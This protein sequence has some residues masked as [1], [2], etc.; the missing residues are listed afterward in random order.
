MAKYAVIDIG[1]NS[2]KLSIFKVSGNNLL[3]GCDKI[4][5]SRI[6]ENVSKTNLISQ[7]GMDRTIQVFEEWK[8]LFQAVNEVKIVGTM[9]FRL[10]KNSNI[11]TKHLKQKYG[12][13]L[14]IISGDK[15]AELSFKA[16]SY[17]YLNSNLP[18]LLIDSG[19]ASTELILF[20]NKKILQ[21]YSFKI[22]AALLTEAA[23]SKN[24]ITKNEIIATKKIIKK[25][26]EKQI[27]NTKINS[28]IAIGG[29]ATSLNNLKNMIFQINTNFISKDKM[30]FLKNILVNS[31]IETRIKELKIEKGRADI[32][33]AGLLILETLQQK[34]NQ[35]LEVNYNGLRHGLALSW[36]ENKM[37]KKDM[38]IIKNSPNLS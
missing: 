17:E 12:F 24:P 25:E 28:L 14:E 11:L 33:P 2:V 35:N 22:G 27:F 21:K 23:I 32:L 30:L 13:N 29:S 26:F 10:A 38:K 18:N 20:Q 15:E 1:T 31:T 37:K 3:W 19:G 6:G 34:F 16:I 9:A 5:I 36:M 8:P 7:L 4:K